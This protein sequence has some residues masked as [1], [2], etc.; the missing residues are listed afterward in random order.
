MPDIVSRIFVWISK[1][2]WFLMKFRSKNIVFDIFSRGIRNWFPVFV[3]FYDKQLF[4]WSKRSKY[5]FCKLSI[6]LMMIW[7]HQHQ[8]N[9][10]INICCT[11]CRVVNSHFNFG[12]GC[13]YLVV[14][15]T[16]DSSILIFVLAKLLIPSAGVIYSGKFHRL[17]TGTSSRPLLRITVPI[18]SLDSH[19]IQKHD[20]YAM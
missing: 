11:K 1:I 3:H 14:F 12:K 5:F 20:I 19:R 13:F 17:N 16:F 6:V 9:K 4:Y 18:E 10:W 7:K 15:L 2:L 8:Q